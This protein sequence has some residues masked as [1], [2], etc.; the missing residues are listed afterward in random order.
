MMN[1]SN[2]CTGLRR[3][4]RSPYGLAPKPPQLEEVLPMFP[5]LQ[6]QGDEREQDKVIDWNIASMIGEILCFHDAKSP[7]L[8]RFYV[9]FTHTEKVGDHTQKT[10]FCSSTRLNS[11]HSS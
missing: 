11:P 2:V 3:L 4:L 10:S 7:L 1:A 9:R 6:G 8:F 5:N